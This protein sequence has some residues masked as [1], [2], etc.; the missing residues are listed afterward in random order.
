MSVATD[1]V[2]ITGSAGMVGS[3][4]IDRY[5]AQLPK[6]KIIGTWFKP[7]IDVNDILSVCNAIEC[8]VTDAEKVFSIIN[9]FRPATIFHL[10]AQSY[11]TVS[12]QK[13]IETINTNMNGTINVFEAVKKIRLHEPDY[14]PMV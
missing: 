5:R 6:E 1:C 9:Q 13:P 8:D 12:W 10:A 14:A 2:M 4:L 3:H 11:P 7:T